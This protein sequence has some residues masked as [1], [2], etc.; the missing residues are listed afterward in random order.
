MKK[1]AKK[2]KRAKGSMANKEE[3][4]IPARR[5]IAAKRTTR[6]KTAARAAVP[7]RQEI[8]IRETRV[9]ESKYYVGPTAAA[10]Q[11]SMMAEL[12]RRDLPGGYAEN[13]LVLQV[14]D[15]WW[16]HAY[17]DFNLDVF[18]KLRNEH[19]AGFDRSHWVL[20]AYDISYINFDGTNA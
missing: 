11:R 14:R 17:W 3:A 19:G 4:R 18:A 10:Y 2:T 15:P 16:V 20:R 5:K 9:E 6:T 13:I 8:P 1:E 12:E 7:N